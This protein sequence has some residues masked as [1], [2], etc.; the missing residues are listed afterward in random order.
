MYIW[1]Y[2]TLYISIYEKCTHD[3]NQ[4]IHTIPMYVSQAASSSIAVFGGK[5]RFTGK[6]YDGSMAASRPYWK[7]L[8][9]GANV[10]HPKQIGYIHSNRGLGVHNK[11]WQDI[12]PYRE[13]FMLIPIWGRFPHHPLRLCSYLM[14]IILQA[15]SRFPGAPLKTGDLHLFVNF[16]SESLMRAIIRM[17][18]WG[19]FSYI[20][21][22]LHILKFCIELLAPVPFYHPFTTWLI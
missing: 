21:L 22:A 14:V 15:L 10:E 11:T 18:S 17:L 1:L 16:C 12:S 3:P 13:S 5:L 6:V 9:G 2:T 19:L 7:T 20:Y 4:T 8:D